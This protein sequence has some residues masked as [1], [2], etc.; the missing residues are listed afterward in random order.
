[1]RRGDGVANDI[2][3]AKACGTCCGSGRVFKGLGVNEDE[4][5]CPACALAPAPKPAVQIGI[6]TATP[7]ADAFAQNRAVLPD[8]MNL[9]RELER[10]RAALLAFV[11]LVRDKDD[12]AIAEVFA[13]APEMLSEDSFRTR[14]IADEIIFKFPLDSVLR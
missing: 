3:K 10:Q 12:A 5:D 2:E 6:S 11:R 14:N 9:I 13:T 1:M 7:I 8:A 4:T